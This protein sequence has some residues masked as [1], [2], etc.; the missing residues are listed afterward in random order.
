MTPWTALSASCIAAMAAV[1]AAGQAR[2]QEIT[3]VNWSPMREVV[4]HSSN[5]PSSGTEADRQMLQ[6]IWGRELTSTR[7]SASGQALPAFALVGDVQ[8]GG[9]R[10]VFSMFSKAGTDR[11]EDPENGAQVTD[12]Y[13]VCSLRVTPWPMQGRQVA[14]LPG[15]CMIFGTQRDKSRIEYAFDATD[16]LLRLRAIQFGKVVPACSRSLRLG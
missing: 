15:Y 2:A 1:L 13:S 6:S 5:F 7:K 14:D 9:R 12:I 10:V 3:E 4:F 16:S 11:C 8:R